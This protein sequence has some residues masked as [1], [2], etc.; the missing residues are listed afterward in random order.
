MLKNRINQYI[1]HCATI[2][3]PILTIEIETMW[4]AVILRGANGN[5]KKEI[6]FT[7]VY[8]LDIVQVFKRGISNT[9]N[10]LIYYS[11]IK[12]DDPDF[13]LPIRDIFDDNDEFGCY[14]AKIREPAGMNYL[15]LF[16]IYI[17][18]KNET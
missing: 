3:F 9:K 6:P 10:H 15:T 11:K 14:Y 18:N 17:L 8:S 4:F 12:N 13:K 7:W 2:F 16:C 1:F 5:V